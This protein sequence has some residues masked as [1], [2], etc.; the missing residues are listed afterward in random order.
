MAV[1]P[2]STAAPARRPNR[3]VLAKNKSA[4]AAAQRI[5]LPPAATVA[6]TDDRDTRA[7]Q[8]VTRVEMLM[9]KGVTRPE[10]VG[11]LLD[12]PTRT[13]TRYIARVH[14]RWEI[15]GGGRTIT[16]FRGEA[17]ARLDLVEQEAWSKYGNQEAARDQVA[18][19]KLILDIATQRSTLLGL[20]PKV[21]ERIALMPEQQHE[22]LSRLTAHKGLADMAGRLTQIV[23]ERRA[24][25]GLVT[26]TIEA[27][28]VDDGE[29]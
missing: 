17:L 3:R 23:A 11:R 5:H 8:D 9:L 1:Q 20:S 4:S 29:V 21:V 13:V 2:K 7:D 28:P 26:K 14:A 19:L 6:A 24:A 15:S 18:F 16:R 10:V 25:L 22:L 12:L 27:D